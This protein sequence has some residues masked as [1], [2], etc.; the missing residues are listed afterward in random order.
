[1][2][3]PN[4]ARAKSEDCTRGRYAHVVKR[5]AWFIGALALVLSACG[6]AP[7]LGSAELAWCV[8]KVA[9]GANPID[10]A[11]RVEGVPTA[12]AWVAAKL[13]LDVDVE[14]WIDLAWVMQVEV[15]DGVE[16]GDISAFDAFVEQYDSDLRRIYEAYFAESDGAAACEAAYELR[17]GA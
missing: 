17:T 11:A 10:Q 4:I 13:E 12:A 6:G 8:S 3:E 2:R 15:P 5:S 14:N 7:D 16:E 9:P 1:M